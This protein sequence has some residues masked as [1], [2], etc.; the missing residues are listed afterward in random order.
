VVFADGS[1][2]QLAAWQGSLQSGE[3]M[4]AAISCLGVPAPGS[5]T[6]KL[7]LSTTA[8]TVGSIASATA[9]AYILVEDIGAD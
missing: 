3:R 1:N 9:P 2:N 7:R 6:V 4:S 8:G 5:F